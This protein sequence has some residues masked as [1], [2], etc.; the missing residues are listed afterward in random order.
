MPIITKPAISKGS[1]ASITLDKS[2]LAA[3]PL[4]SGDSYFSV[5]ANWNKIRVYFSAAGGQREVLTFDATQSSPAAQFNV[6]ARARDVFQVQKITIIDFDGGSLDIPRSA[7]NAAEFDVDLSGLSF[8]W[9]RAASV[10]AFGDSGLQ[11][12]SLGSFAN[13]SITQAINGDF[14]VTMTIE[15]TALSSDFLAG[16]ALSALDLSG[17]INAY[18]P[19]HIINGSYGS[20][21]PGQNALEWGLGMED[22]P[23]GVFGVGTGVYKIRFTRVGST[24][25]YQLTNTSNVV[26]SSGNAKT[27]YTGPVYF[28]FCPFNLNIRLNSIV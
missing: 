20:P 9:N 23:S 10:T 2:S 24:I 13:G 14:D 18:N 19:A 5:Q 16:F 6:S 1:P 17:G 7:L 11:T 27:G 12:S 22:N 28:V 21:Q 26:F 4:V 3:L 15:M 25:T 8:T